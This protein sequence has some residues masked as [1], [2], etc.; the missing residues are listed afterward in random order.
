[1]EEPTEEQ[2]EAERRADAMLVLWELPH[3][4]HPRRRPL[5]LSTTRRY[6]KALRN[7]VLCEVLAYSLYAQMEKRR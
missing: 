3:I 6:V 7:T 2:L 5:Q 1:M 4:D